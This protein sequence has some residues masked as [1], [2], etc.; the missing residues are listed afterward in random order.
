MTANPFTLGFLVDG[1]PQQAF[2]AINDVR[3]WWSEDFTGASRQ[4][5]DEFEVRFSN[6]HYSRHKLEYIVPAQKIV[7]LVTDSYLSFLKDKGE[8][9]GTKTLFEISTQDGQT[10]ISF[11]HLGLVPQLECFRDCSNGWTHYL[12]SLKNFIATGKGDPNVLK[13]QADE[14]AP[15]VSSQLNS[16]S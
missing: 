13:K 14:K 10:K 5:G 11:T 9:T 12:H 16:V 3:G 2:D 1:T 8:W 4:E 7:W 15:S 6:V